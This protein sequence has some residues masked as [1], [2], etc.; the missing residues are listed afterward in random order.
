MLTTAS[1]AMD[2]DEAAQFLSQDTDI[3]DTYHNDDCQALTKWWV[4]ERFAP[5][6]LPYQADLV[7]GL[8]EMVE[9]QVGFRPSC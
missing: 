2:L 1:D 8:M 3:P 6:L 7:S 5:E 4:N 9:H